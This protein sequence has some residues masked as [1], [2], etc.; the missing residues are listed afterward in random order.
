MKDVFLNWHLG[1]NFGWG[2]A[3]SISSVIGRTIPRSGRLWDNRSRAKRWGCW[4]R[5][6]WP[7]S[8]RRS[9]FPTAF[10]EIVAA[11]EYVY[12]N[13]QGTREIGRRSRE[14]LIEHGRTWQAHARELKAWILSLWHPTSRPGVPDPSLPK[15]LFLVQRSPAL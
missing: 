14:W 15:T 10:C 6:A 2:I 3:G 13:R 11:L 5:C 12:A 1:N 7:E 4:I 9:N 8:T